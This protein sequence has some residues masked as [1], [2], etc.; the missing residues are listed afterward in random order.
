MKTVEQIREHVVDQ[1]KIFRQ[2]E[3]EAS[4]REQTY[5]EYAYDATASYFRDLLVYIDDE[6]ES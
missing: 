2:L 4:R 5:S 6:E 1:I 3:K